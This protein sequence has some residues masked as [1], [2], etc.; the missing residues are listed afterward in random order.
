MDNRINRKKRIR[1]KLTGITVRPRLSVFRSNNNLYLQV[2]DDSKGMTI[3]SASTLK[4]KDPAQELTQKLLKKNIKKIVFD[5]SGYQYHG[6]VQK[7][8]EDLR[9]AGLEF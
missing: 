5:R 3:A 6:R 8:A 9:K 2:I 4:S 1:G 7:I